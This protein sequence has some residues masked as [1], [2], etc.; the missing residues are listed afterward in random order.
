LVAFLDEIS[1]DELSAYWI[2]TIEHDH[3]HTG[4]R[5]GLHGMSHGPDVRVV[6]GADILDIEY[7][8]VETIQHDPS[9][10]ARGTVQ[11]PHGKAG[12]PVDLILELDLILRKPSQT[13]LGPEEHR[14]SGFGIVKPIDGVPHRWIDRRWICDEPQTLSSDA[15]GL[16][17]EEA[18][19]SGFYFHHPAATP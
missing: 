17:L 19:E 6:A 14:Q 12:L 1:L 7:D 4:F 9:G 13:M 16:I 15:F 11:T 10:H 18:N 5:A 8:R 3:L 2:G